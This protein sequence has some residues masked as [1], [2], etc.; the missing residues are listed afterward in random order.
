[1]TEAQKA[2]MERAL[3][4]V[5]RGGVVPAVGGIEV[6]DEHGGVETLSADGTCT[7]GEEC[8]VHWMARAY[9]RIIDRINDNDTQGLLRREPAEMLLAATVIAAAR[10]NEERDLAESAYTPVPAPS[11]PYTSVMDAIQHHQRVQRA[12][13]ERAARDDAIRFANHRAHF[14]GA[15]FARLLEELGVRGRE[16]VFSYSY[17]GRDYLVEVYNESGRG[18]RVMLAEEARALAED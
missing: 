7:C 1:M 10:A 12:G 18:A 5:V 4:Y 2:K 3:E 16:E 6:T 14:A 11:L 13:Q 17:G 15:A 8:C 9:E